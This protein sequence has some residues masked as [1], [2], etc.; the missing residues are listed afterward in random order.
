MQ[1]AWAPRNHFPSRKGRETERERGGE[2]E[3]NKYQSSS[4]L[5]LLPRNPSF[6]G[7]GF[8]AANSAY[9]VHASHHGG[10]G[11]REGVCAVFSPN[12]QICP[13]MIRQSGNFPVT[14]CMSNQPSCTRGFENW[15][16]VYK[17]LGMQLDLFYK[18]LT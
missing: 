11:E 16:D 13:P 10:E 12:P 1:C 18:Y 7:A 6:S 15:L 4:L 17:K 9:N 2:E 3:E 5:C 8:F 14:V